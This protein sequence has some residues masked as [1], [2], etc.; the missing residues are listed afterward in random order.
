MLPNLMS[1]FMECPI[2]GYDM[3]VKNRKITRSSIGRVYDW[4]QYHCKRD[5]VWAEVEI[6]HQEDDK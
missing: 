6:P 2:C 4:T 1:N 3:S 5:D